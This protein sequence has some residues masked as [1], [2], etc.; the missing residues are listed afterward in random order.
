MKKIP[1]VLLLLKA[2]LNMLTAAID[3]IASDPLPAYTGPRIPGGQAFR[4]YTQE[5]T[6]PRLPKI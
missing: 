2:R 5:L 1:S 6:K 4:I 3:N